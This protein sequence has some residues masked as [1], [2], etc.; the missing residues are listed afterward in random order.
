MCTTILS[1]FDRLRLSFV[2][3][4]L[5]QMRLGPDNSQNPAMIQFFTWDAQ[6][7]DMSWW[8]HFKTELPR[9]AELGFTQAWLPPPNKGMNGKWD[10][11][12]FDQ[13]GTIPTRWGTREE[14]SQ[15]CSAARQDNVGVIIDAVLNHKIGA[16]RPET[17]SAVRVDPENRVRDLE[18]EREIRGWTAFDFP[19]RQGKYSGMK[20]T[21]KHFTGLDWDDLTQTN[22]IYRISSKQW[23]TRVDTELGNYDYL[24]G[25]DIDHGHPAVRDDLH[26]WGSWILDVMSGSGFRLDA[27]KHIDR[28][29]L[30]EFIQRARGAPNRERLFVVAEYWT[31]K[32][33]LPSIRAFRGQ[34]AFFDV[35]LHENFHQASKS[36]SSYDLRRILDKSLVA[37]RPG[38][39]VT[40][41]DNHEVMQQIGQSLESWV[42]TNFKVQAYALILLRCDGFPCVFYGDLYPNQECFDEATSDK[43]IRLLTARKMFAYGPL[44]DYFLYRNCI[45]FVRMGDSEHAGCVV[46]MSNESP[47]LGKMT[48]PII[49]MNVGPCGRSAVFR[50]FL[51]TS[52]RVAVDSKGWGDFYCSRNA[53]EV[54]IKD[55]AVPQE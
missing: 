12:E 37:I 35:P 38:D 31:A 41:V 17:F 42:G 46:V 3:P 33:L 20:W 49:R 34:A 19:G 26:A 4:A 13:K 45:G 10:L 24:L 15:A 53:V 51:D 43:I 52:R 55:A 21:H 6:H 32:L 14:L 11:G 48:S 7:P 29:F 18:Q 8:K 40:F 47:A 50:G 9:L 36:G 30:L 27:I 16:D 44:K 5:P 2:G 39:A 25:V 22:G 23:S 1:W 54:W 28:N